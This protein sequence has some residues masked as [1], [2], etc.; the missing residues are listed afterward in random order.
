M[1]LGRKRWFLFPLFGHL[2]PLELSP[3][4]NGLNALVMGAARA[5]EEDP[6]GLD[7]VTDNFAA[8]MD[9]GRCKGVDGAFE[10]IKITGDAVDQDFER[11]V[12]IVSANLALH[13]IPSLAHYS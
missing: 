3:V 12:V 1:D 9:A 8:T 11:L 7:S 5:T 13:R 4:T 2:N 6:T 10:R